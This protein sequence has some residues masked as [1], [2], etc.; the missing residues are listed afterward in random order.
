MAIEQ[1]D[2][3]GRSISVETGTLAKQADGSVCV[4]VGDTITL[5][6]VAMAAPREGIDFFPLL[7]DFEERM[8]A[9]GKI[10]GV[11]YIRREGRPSEN[12]ILSARRI[13]RAIRPLFPKGFRN[14]I[15]IVA[16]VLSV[17][18]EN[19]AD[20][21]AMV[22]ASAA[23]CVSSVPFLGP[24][25]TVRVGRVE[26]RLTINPTYAERDQSDLD[27]TVAV[28]PD[29]IVMLEGM[30]DQL[31]EAAVVE[32]IAFAL[33]YAE[34]IIEMQRSLMAAAGKKKVEVE[35]VKVGDDIR[36]AIGRFSGTI[37]E[38]MQNPDKTAR[39][40]ATAEIMNQLGTD[41]ADEFPERMPEIRV[42]LEEQTDA[43]LRG[44]ILDDGRRPDGRTP[45]EI[46]PVSCEVG[47]L[48][49]AH[50][51]G[52]FTRGQTQVMSVVTLGGVGDEQL[53][54]DLGVVESKRFMHH[55]NFP[56]YS[57]G[58][59][60]PMRGPSRR[61]LGHGSLVE[62]ALLP[63]LPDEEEFPY[64]VRVV[65]EVLESNGSSSMA[66][67][68]GSSLGLMDAG[69]P[70]RAPI[71]GISIGM[72]SD[73]DRRKLLT[74]IQGV[75]DFS[76]DMDFKV[77]GTREGITAVQMDVKLHGL[78]MDT[79]TEAFEQAQRA[80]VFLLDTMER[81]IA[82]P[83]PELAPHAPRVFT[84]IIDPE[85]IGDVIGPGG[86]MIRRLEAD[87]ECKIDIEQEGRVFIA[88]PDQASGEKA[89][90]AIEDLTRDLKVGETYSGKVVRITPFGAFLELLP[91]RDGLL[92]ISQIARERIERVEDVLSMGDEVPVRV[93]E[94][95]PQGK[96]RLSRKDLLPPGEGDERRPPSAGGRGDRRE[97]GRGGGGDSGRSRGRRDRR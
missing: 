62:R 67:V 1:R 38:A 27:L 79:V 93:I 29:G 74:D 49:R 82:A 54:D 19:A 80:R 89:L 69:V 56:P 87:F 68:C 20:I 85:K 90:K 76:G 14:D 41:L 70:I 95:D 7:V 9:A 75:E 42:A 72:V 78:T 65:S 81:T 35:G 92:H 63:V 83:R 96:V 34:Q 25:G 5:V 64:T 94:I 21:P 45:E 22:G 57:V 16:T 46:R 97:S 51:S 4:R 31:P 26:G 2:L 18:M 37:R 6:T 13:D 84:L 59:V 86:K 43:E 88:A 32:A 66:S 10:P 73:G 91:G 55:Y 24:V 58:E 77:G 52:L 40:E 50:G 36:A 28:T 39:E 15:Q 33:P 23:L 47:L 48:P 8:Y 61:D 44:L 11:R 60:R 53:I 3:D 12:A 71:A 30:A 17:D